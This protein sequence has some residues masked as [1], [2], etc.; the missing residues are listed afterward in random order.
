MEVIWV[1]SDDGLLYLIID[2]GKNWVDVILFNFGEVYI[3][4]IE[5]FFYDFDWVYVVVMKY[6]FNNFEFL[7][8]LFEDKGVI[9]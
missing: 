5:V 4:C 2:D 6:K 3:N 8:Y 1:G 9:W 7:V